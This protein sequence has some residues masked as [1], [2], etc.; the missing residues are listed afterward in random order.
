MGYLYTKGATRAA[1]ATTAPAADLLAGI[2]VNALLKALRNLGE[3]SPPPAEVELRRNVI[4]LAGVE[5][6]KALRDLL[7]ALQSA[8]ARDLAA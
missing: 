7:Q 3:V 2:D 1:T 5:Q 6:V 4:A 8:G